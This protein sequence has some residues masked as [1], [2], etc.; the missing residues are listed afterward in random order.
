MRLSFM[1]GTVTFT[2]SADE[3]KIKGANTNIEI[4]FKQIIIFDKTNI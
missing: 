2:R 1:A 4:S 3:D